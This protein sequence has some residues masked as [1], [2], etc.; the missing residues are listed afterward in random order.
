[1]FFTMLILLR[2]YFDVNNDWLNGGERN[3]SL[4]EFSSDRN[5]DHTK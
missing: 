3:L 5:L 1:M 2:S 4:E